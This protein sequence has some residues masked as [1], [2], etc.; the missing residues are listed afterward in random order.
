MS[1]AL[2]AIACIHA[3]IFAGMLE[4]LGNLIG[5]MFKHEH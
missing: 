2:L 3:I 4:L 5:S 1:L